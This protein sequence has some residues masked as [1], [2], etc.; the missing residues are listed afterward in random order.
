[1]CS[2]VVGCRAGSRQLPA[3]G[4]PVLRWTH[5]FE[6]GTRAKDGRRLNLHNPGHVL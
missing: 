6:F 1:M 5:A 3:T 2:G 4:V